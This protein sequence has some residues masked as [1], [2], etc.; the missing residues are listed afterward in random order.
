MPDAGGDVRA[1]VGVELGI[2]DRSVAAVV[3]VPAPVGALRCRRATRRPAR[4]RRACR[5]RRA[6]SPSP[7]GSTDRSGRPRTTGSSRT[8]AAAAAML[9]RGLGAPRRRS[10]RRATLGQRLSAA[11]RRSD[12][13]PA[14]GVDDDALAQHR[15]EGR[16]RRAGDL[17][18]FTMSHSRNLPVRDHRAVVVVASGRRRTSATSTASAARGRG[19][20]LAAQAGAAQLGPQLG[21]A[22]R[23]AR[24]RLR[25]WA[26]G[27]RPR[28]SS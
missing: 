9:V 10:R 11:C 5:R 28:A 14:S 3:V 22:S 18:R 19:G 12:A 16:G 20:C 4:P 17:G 7:R 21:R 26:R 6:P 2:L 1:D 13:A 27:T 25:R 23:C 8:G 15:V 24:G